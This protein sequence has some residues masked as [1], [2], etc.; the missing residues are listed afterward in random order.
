M[1]S[2]PSEQKDIPPTSQEDEKIE[3]TEKS[4]KTEQQSEKIEEITLPEDMS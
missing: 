2:A 3:I 1:E 4:N